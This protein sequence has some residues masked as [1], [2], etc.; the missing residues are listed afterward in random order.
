MAEVSDMTE[1]DKVNS[2]KAVVSPRVQ[3]TPCQRVADVSSGHVQ[4]E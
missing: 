3:T 4:N 2:D 1:G